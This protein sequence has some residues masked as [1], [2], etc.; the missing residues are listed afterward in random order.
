MKKRKIRVC[1]V[2]PLPPPYG[3]IANWTAMIQKYL[4]ENY[5]DRIEYNIVNTSPGKR[6]TE[7]RSSWERV[8][9][10]GIGMLRVRRQIK[11]LLRKR[12]DCVHLATSGS[13]SV[14]R[15]FFIARLLIKNNIP[16]VYHIHFGRIPELMEKN[17]LEWKLLDYVIKISKTTITIDKM[18]YERIKN[19]CNDKV[20]YIPNPINSKDMPKAKK[21]NSKK[22]MFLG[23]VV[24]EK[25]IE[26]L[27]A[28]WQ[29]LSLKHKEWKLEIVGPYKE[30]YKQSLLERYNCERINFHGE[31]PH[32]QA[33]ELLNDSEIFCL[34]SYT[35][36]CPYVIM[37]ALMLG[38]V[39]VATDVGNIPEMVQEDN[40]FIVPSKNKKKLERALEQGIRHCDTYDMDCIAEDALRRYDIQSIVKKY[41]KEWIQ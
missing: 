31:K 23:W 39:I 28:A 2:S 41:I 20:V 16:F 7:G 11:Y 8:I 36:G 9:G 5:F 1:F 27:L 34:P 13:L 24:K 30:E 26:E 19:Q 29:I 25:G 17:N 15:D 40:G 21:S 22:V 4:D 32:K 10:G 33:M 37:E 12:V 35:E 3:G 18:T 14:F 38:K 6:V